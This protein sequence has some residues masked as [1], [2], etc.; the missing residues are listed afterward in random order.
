MFKLLRESRGLLTLVVYFENVD[1]ESCDMLPEVVYFEN[2]R[3]FLS[4][5]LLNMMTFSKS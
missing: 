3:G 1:F 4:D 5:F 2:S